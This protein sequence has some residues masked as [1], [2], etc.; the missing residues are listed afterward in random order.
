[1]VHKHNHISTGLLEDLEEIENSGLAISIGTD[2]GK[3][4]LDY[5]SLAFTPE[6]E[7]IYLDTFVKIKKKL[8]PP[9]NSGNLIDFKG[10]SLMVMDD[11]E[12]LVLNTFSREIKGCMLCMQLYG[13]I[14]DKYVKKGEETITQL[15]EDLKSSDDDNY[16]RFISGIIKKS[17]KLEEYDFLNLL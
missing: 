16:K 6:E 7:K 3:R 10:K 13:A 9:K 11:L 17:K 4:V 15:E 5:A 8:L 1:M 2:Y 12:A 14:I